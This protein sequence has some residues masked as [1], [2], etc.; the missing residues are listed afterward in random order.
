[1]WVLAVW[2]AACAGYS[3][4]E[5]VEADGSAKAII[6]NIARLHVLPALKSNGVS[7]ATQAA[8]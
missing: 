5:A 8:A 2:L 7:L 1:M 6:A 3:S 4:K